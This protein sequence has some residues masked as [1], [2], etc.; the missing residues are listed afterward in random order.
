VQLFLKNKI[1]FFAKN[2]CEIQVC[3]KLV[4]ALYAIKYGNCNIRAEQKNLF[5]KEKEQSEIQS[6]PK[7]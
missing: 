5:M 1:H 6:K 3:T 2:D 7:V 4:C